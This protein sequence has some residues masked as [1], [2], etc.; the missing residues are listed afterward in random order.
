M[1]EEFIF[2]HDMDDNGLMYWMGSFGKRKTWQNPHKI[3][4]VTVFASS[5]GAGA[6]EDI[7]GRT[8]TNC[9]TINEYGAFFG[10]DLGEDRHFLPSRY[11]LRNRNS[12]SYILC[13]WMF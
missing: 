13:N 4:Q 2:E 5:V 1:P 3:Q 11:S 9:R 8:A 12:T 7:V 10:I 6:L